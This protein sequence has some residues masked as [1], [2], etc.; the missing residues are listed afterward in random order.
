M[1]NFGFSIVL[2]NTSDSHRYI[3]AHLLPKLDVSYLQCLFQNV[4]GHNGAKL[5]TINK[6]T[7][8]CMQ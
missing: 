1:L 6:V 2:F 3:N 4:C 7:Y 8:N 5:V